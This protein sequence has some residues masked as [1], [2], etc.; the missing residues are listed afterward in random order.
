MN[1]AHMGG[2]R[3]AHGVFVGTSEGKRTLGLSRHILECNIK[4][5]L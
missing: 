2:C 1:V 3:N 4:M 5:D